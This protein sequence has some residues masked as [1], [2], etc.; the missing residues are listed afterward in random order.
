MAADAV[1][2]DN[3]IRFAWV[4]M[5]EIYY[6]NLIIE[7]GLPGDDVY[8]RLE[9]DKNGDGVLTFTYNGKTKTFADK[10][11]TKFQ[12]VGDNEKETCTMEFDCP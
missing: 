1:L 3:G 7:S 4:P 5:S 10:Q 9:V 2:D 11:C 8:A 6:T 12:G